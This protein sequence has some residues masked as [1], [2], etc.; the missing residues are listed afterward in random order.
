ML[1]SLQES[2]HYVWFPQQLLCT[3]SEGKSEFLSGLVKHAADNTVT[4]FWSRACQQFLV[5]PKCIPGSAMNRKNQSLVP[6]AWVP[7]VS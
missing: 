7:P 1:R 4:N 6:H 2:L 3:L 5:L